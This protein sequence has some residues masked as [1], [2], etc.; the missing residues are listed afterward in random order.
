MSDY[1]PSL[2]EQE[3]SELNSRLLTL[4][5]KGLF[6]RVIAYGL[7]I[8]AA[9]SALIIALDIAH[10]L[11]RMLAAA[12]LIALFIRGNYPFGLDRNCGGI[13]QRTGAQ[14]GTSELRRRPGDSG[15]WLP[16]WPPISGRG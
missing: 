7:K 4:Q 2:I 12:T 3:I 11:D 10:D 14:C 15:P 5:K 6:R 9:G 8:V 13:N 16:G 1:D